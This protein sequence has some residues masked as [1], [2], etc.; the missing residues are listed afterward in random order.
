MGVEGGGAVESISDAGIGALM[1][2]GTGTTATGAVAVAGAEAA[3][4]GAGDLF[5]MVGKVFGDDEEY[6][7]SES[8]SSLFCRLPRRG[9][10]I[11]A[12]LSAV[13][14]LVAVG[15]CWRSITCFWRVPSCSISDWFWLV[16]D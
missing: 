7:L 14:M 16:S 11:S 2:G 15:Q 5:V 12:R 1:G 10:M 8:S 9:V 6:D 3:V 4:G 13:V